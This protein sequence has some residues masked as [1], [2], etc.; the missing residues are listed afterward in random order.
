MQVQL[1]AL[2]GY[3]EPSTLSGVN[4]SI[5]YFCSVGIANVVL[6]IVKFLAS[7]MPTFLVWFKVIV[8]SCLMVLY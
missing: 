6:A 3:T 4:W 7:Y 8:H 2:V 1:D 5:S